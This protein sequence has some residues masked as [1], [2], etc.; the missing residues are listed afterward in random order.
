MTNE[1]LLPPTSVVADEEVEKL[2]GQSSQDSIV[3]VVGSEDG[4]K[5]IDGIKEKSKQ[6]SKT[7]PWH[8]AKRLDH[9]LAK[10]ERPVLDFLFPGFRMGRVGGLV[11]AGGIGKSM[12][13]LELAVA[14]ACPLKEANLLGIE[15]PEH[16]RVLYLSGED[17]IEEFQ[18]R[19]HSIHKILELSGKGE[20][21]VAHLQQNLEI[22]DLEDSPRDFLEY[23][24]FEKFNSWA[25]DVRLVII[26][27][28][29][30]FHSG[31]ENSN[32][33]MSKLISLFKLIA[34]RNGCCVLYL[35]HTSKGMAK[36]NRQ[37]EQQSTRGAS[38]LVDNCRMICYLA[39]MSKEEYGRLKRENGDS[40]PF[41]ESERKR[42]VTFGISKQNGGGHVDPFWLTRA[43]GGVL[44]R[45]A[46]NFWGVMGSDYTQQS[47]KTSGK[48]KKK[49]NV[50]RVFV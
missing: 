36:D 26:D 14:V 45:K 17:D 30:M 48:E 16:G 11:S 12:L 15:V 50:E 7:D 37:D 24:V 27:T 39:G 46:T 33:E 8:A 6:N 29:S 25:K 31:D 9:H 2:L 41:P 42:W 1:I 23:A 38:A 18:N 4:A 3:A 34:K 40:M 13:A 49:Q 5:L 44:V 10:K 19:M 43:E 22:V 28:L 47:T 20:E 35:H 21:I 32:T